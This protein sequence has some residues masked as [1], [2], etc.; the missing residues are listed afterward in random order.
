[1]GSPANYEGARV[2]TVREYYPFPRVRVK[3][4]NLPVELTVVTLVTEGFP[5]R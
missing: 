5:E 3:E 1:M 2:P 4:G